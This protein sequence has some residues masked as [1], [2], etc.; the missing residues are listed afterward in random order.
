MEKTNVLEITR[1]T[2]EKELIGEFGANKD[3]YY[4]INLPSPLEEIR[5]VINIPEN[6]L[7][8]G[9]TELVNQQQ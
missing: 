4:I 3:L 7:A 9:V 6:P 2:K 1:I 8:R 5:K